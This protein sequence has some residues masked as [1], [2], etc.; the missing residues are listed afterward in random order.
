[1]WTT[2]WT[3]LMEAVAGL[4]GRVRPNVLILALIILALAGVVVV[5]AHR[6]NE[7]EIMAGVAGVAIGGLLG[8]GNEI[9]KKE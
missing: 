7:S 1:M 5:L 8:F 3:T 4:I 6:A 9:L 2:A